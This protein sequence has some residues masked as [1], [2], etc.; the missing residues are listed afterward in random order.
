MTRRR[1]RPRAPFRA[2]LVLCPRLAQCEPDG[3]KG[4][5]M[6]I[7]KFTATAPAACRHPVRLVLGLLING[8]GACVLLAQW[9]L[10]DV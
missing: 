10:T 4:G 2:W 1:G 6:D 9:F 8:A 7:R 5:Q 3:G